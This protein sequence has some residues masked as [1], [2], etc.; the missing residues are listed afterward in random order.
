MERLGRLVRVR[1]NEE[2]EEQTQRTRLAEM[3]A[4]LAECDVV[5]ESIEGEFDSAGDLRQIRAERASQL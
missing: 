1:V 4:W 5:A 3:D 2:I